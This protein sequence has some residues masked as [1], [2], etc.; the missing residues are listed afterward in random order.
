[1]TDHDDELRRLGN[2]LDIPFEENPEPVYI[3]E[4]FQMSGGVVMMTT[5][6]DVPGVGFLPAI[7][8]RFSNPHGIF[9]P[10][11]LLV[12]DDDQAAK[13]PITVEQTIS[14]ARRFARDRN[15]QEGD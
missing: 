5:A 15:R 7:V 10:P 1:M 3:T 8:F 4:D 11:I 12:V 2:S 9:Y 6:V 14:C 13:F